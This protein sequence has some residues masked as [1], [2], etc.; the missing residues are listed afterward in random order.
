[1]ET[2]CTTQ[3]FHGAE[4][5]VYSPLMQ[6]VL[7][8][9]ER[10]A[11]SHA[12]VLIT[13]ETG[14]GKEIIARA[15]HACSLRCAKPWVDFSC[16]ALP[17]QLMESELFGFEKGAFSGADNFKPGLFEL[18]NGGT[19][20]LDE[21]GE[22]EPKMQVKLLRILDG[23]PYY[24]LGGVRKVSVD[25]RIVAAT[26]RDLEEAS[27]EGRFRQDLFHR[28][29]EIH[30]VVPPLRQRPEDI[31]PLTEF[32]LAKLNSP[33]RFDPRALDALCRF[34][35]P[36][37]VRQLRN[38]VTKAAVD[39][40]HD[41]IELEDLPAAVQDHANPAGLAAEDAGLLNLD[42]LERRTILRAIAESG[43]YQEAAEQLGI[44]RRTLARKM[45]SYQIAEES[46][47]VT[48]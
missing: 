48:S 19:L 46:L 41:V 42:E 32:F 21:V 14:T 9:T 27:R 20:F 17:D 47:E 6:E 13:G 16:A 3:S 29:D 36:G 25:V 26:N 7:R 5:V 18:A 11:R 10:A 22:L 39:S 45:R 37:N 1:M 8:K 34:D 38:F 33:A 2:F 15:I 23:V 43:D 12:A 35:W 28:L 24:R 30:I 44:S 4:A 31:V 40:E